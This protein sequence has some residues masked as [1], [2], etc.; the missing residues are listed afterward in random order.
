[1]S[2]GPA[3]EP[4]TPTQFAPTLHGLGT[5]PQGPSAPLPCWPAPNRPARTRSRGT[6]A[7]PSTPHSTRS[8]RRSRRRQAPAHGPDRPGLKRQAATKAVAAPPASAKQPRSVTMGAA[9]PSQRAG[10][11]ART[12]LRLP[13]QTSSSTMRGS[14]SSLRPASGQLSNGLRQ[15]T[16]KCG[17]VC[18]LIPGRRDAGRGTCGDPVPCVS[19]RAARGVRA[20]RGRSL[21]PPSGDPLRCELHACSPIRRPDQ[22]PR[23]ETPRNREPSKPS[24]RPGHG[25]NAARAPGPT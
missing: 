10:R 18:S 23:R 19:A 25:A 22:D 2:C 7:Q 12:L 13:K 6:A 9:E 1:M 24:E 11:T 21:T 3:E 8:G 15:G 17:G 14:G 4:A 16:P 5:P 20:A